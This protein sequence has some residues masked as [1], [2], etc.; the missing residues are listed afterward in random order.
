[1][2]VDQLEAI[3]AAVPGWVWLV[4]LTVL[5][6]RFVF[7]PFLA[8]REVKSCSE[9]WD[10]HGYSKPDDT[11]EYCPLCG[12]ELTPEYQPGYLFRVADQ[13]RDSIQGALDGVRQRA[14]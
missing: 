14:D 12:E 9:G 5:F 11:Y 1:V 8:R 13:A 7:G 3:A 10:G 4:G 2:I 6:L